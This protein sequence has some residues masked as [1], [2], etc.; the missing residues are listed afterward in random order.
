MPDPPAIQ[1]G[2]V[3]SLGFQGPTQPTA[4]TLQDPNAFYQ[5][6][7]GSTTGGQDTP[8]QTPAGI[9]LA[10]IRQVAS[11]SISYAQRV[12]AA[13]DR[14]Q[15]QSSLYPAAGQ[16]AL[17][18]QLKI[19]ARLIAGGLKTRIYLV[20][21]SGF[22]NHSSQVLSGDTTSGTHAT[23]LGKLAAAVYAF[24]DD[25]QI[26]G[27]DHRVIAMTFSEFGR[28]VASNSSLGTDHG[29]A[30]PMFLFGS[31]VRAGVVGAN[32]SLT[33]LTS[34][35]LKMQ[36]DFR[37]VYAAVLNQWFGA[38]QSEL[39]AVLLKSFQPLDL[40]RTIPMRPRRRPIVA[41]LG[42]SKT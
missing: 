29:T 27:A 6:V 38:G 14:A 37:A 40:I 18:D 5:L 34:G 13:A 39:D 1:I 11:Q 31:S 42:N 28:R 41:A 36:F 3:V 33:D 20:N 26:Q 17:A 35:N 16:N 32:P 7:G 2:S 19:V 9:E 15:N 10:F 25:L 8:P 23:L 22:D 4:I 30:I 12:K 24:Q 21:L